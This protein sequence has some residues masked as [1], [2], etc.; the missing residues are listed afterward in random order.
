VVKKVN[1]TL[2]TLSLEK[3]FHGGEKM[4]VFIACSCDLFL[5]YGDYTMFQYFFWAVFTIYL[6]HLEVNISRFD[7]FGHQ[8]M[9]NFTL[10]TFVCFQEEYMISKMYEWFRQ[11]IQWSCTNFVFCLICT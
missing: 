9:N 11:L 2:L 6:F 8:K 4:Y 7:S 3:D 1:I 10:F 5:G